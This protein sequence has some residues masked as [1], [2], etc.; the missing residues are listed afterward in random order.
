MPVRTGVGLSSVTALVEETE[1]SAELTA[2]MVRAFEEGSVAGATYLPEASMVPREE[3]P[4]AALLT[5]HET[6]ESWVPL[7]TAEKVVEP[8]ARTLADAGETT[9]ETCAGGGGCFVLDEVG[10]EAQEVGPTAKGRT[11]TIQN[12]RGKEKRIQQQFG[13]RQQFGILAERTETGQPFRQ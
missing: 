11:G 2:L 5:S 12:R 10:P 6:A 1:E 7:T 13:R 3:D 4:P 9:M 8:P